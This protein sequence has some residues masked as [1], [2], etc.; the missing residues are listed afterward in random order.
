M[1]KFG[2]R[3]SKPL[4][5]CLTEVAKS[6]I[7]IGLI[8][9]RYGSVDKVS[10]KS[11]TQL[12]YEH[13][14]S[15]GLEILIYIIDEECPVI[16]KYID[17]GEKA[18]KLIQ[19]KELLRNA[20]TV[21]T[22]KDETTLAKKITDRLRE[23]YPQS[24]YSFYRPKVIDCKVSRFSIG[25]EKW[26]VFLGIFSGRLVEIFTGI[27]DD[28]MFPIP[29]SITQGKIIKNHDNK[30]NVRYDFQYKDKYGYKNTLG[31]I[32][33]EFFRD[34]ANYTRIINDLLRDEISLNRLIEIIDNM[35]TT[36]LTPSSDWKSGV[37]TAIKNTSLY[38]SGS[39]KSN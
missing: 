26:L 28:E 15:L 38:S 17:I 29:L 2:A 18:E 1:E 27:M 14:L 9:T 32:S 37:I 10:G 33:H 7:Y 23:L 31:G 4:S 36:V 5:T 21:D 8:G 11:F 20:H 30:N 35:N 39:R 25:K 24:I 34:V 19:F 13:A 22:F 6:D 3:K 16:L 12:E